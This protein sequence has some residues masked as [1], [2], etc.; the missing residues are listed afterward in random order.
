MAK[1]KP[2]DTVK[3]EAIWKALSEVQVPHLGRHLMELGIAKRFDETDTA[4]VLYLQFPAGVAVEDQVA[5]ERECELRLQ[6][7]AAHKSIQIMRQNPP[8]L[9]QQPRPSSP[10]PAQKGGVSGVNHIVLVASGKGGVGKSTVAL[11]LALALRRQDARV[12][13]LDADLFGPSVPTMSGLGG[14]RPQ[15]VD[16]TIIPLERGGVSIVSIGFLVSSAQPVVWRG[17][18]V[19]SALTQLLQKVKW[20][21]LDYLIVDMPPGTGDTQLSMAQSV[22]VSG[23]L[24]VTTPQKVSSADVRRAL[25]MLQ[26]VQ[27]PLLGI[28][29]NMHSFVCAHC[30]SETEIFGSGGAHALSDE[31]GIPVL[32]QLPYSRSLFELSDEGKLLGVDNVSETLSAASAK[33]Q[34]AAL[35]AFNHLAC[36]VMHALPVANAQEVLP[37]GHLGFRP[38]KLEWK[39]EGRA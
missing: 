29:E 27:V 2:A 39:P 35:H 30:E 15:I 6:K 24:V 12:G 17:P 32:A 33:T 5:V 28:V 13:L 11:N 4:L 37:T 16:D 9:Q 20:G 10:P 1:N 26:M 34:E 19:H 14:Q 22:T 8:S 18:M 25:Q 21:A 7:L 31:F 36:E 23:A 38:Q 3:K